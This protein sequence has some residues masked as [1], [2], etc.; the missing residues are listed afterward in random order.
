[1]KLETHLYKLTTIHQTVGTINSP[2]VY[3]NC[4]DKGTPFNLSSAACV[5]VVVI[6]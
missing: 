1:M 6:C 5:S 2:V 3:H 4:P